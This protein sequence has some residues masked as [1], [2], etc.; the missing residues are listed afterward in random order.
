M[1]L[2]EFGLGHRAESAVFIQRVAHLYQ[3]CGGELIT[4]TDIYRGD[5]AEIKLKM[6]VYTKQL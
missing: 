1:V 5:R 4:R 3:L 6:I 2:E